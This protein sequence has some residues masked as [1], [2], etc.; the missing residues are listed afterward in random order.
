MKDSE[1][2]RR[3]KNRDEV[4]VS[5]LYDKYAAALFG[6]INK[7][8]DDPGLAEEVLSQTVL[9]TWN[10]IDNY[11]HD[12]SN[13][14]TWL[15]TIA[16][17][18]AI[19]HKRLKSY[20]N[21][22]K[23][24]SL[25]LPVYNIASKESTSNMDAEKIIGLLD[26]KYKEVLSKI[27]LDGYSQSETSDLLNIPLGTVKSRLRKAILILREELK[28]ERKFYYGTLLSIFLLVISG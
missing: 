21:H 26:E 24:E 28:S 20:Q 10:K 17:N 12:K 23:T 27:Y 14:F 7:I 15:M 5:M 3:I 13:L 25:S 22:K 2:V 11:S 6:I 18:T 1:I 4:G 9:K 19:D 8:L 16:R